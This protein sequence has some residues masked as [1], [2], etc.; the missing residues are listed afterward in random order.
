MRC[1]A[2]LAP[3]LVLALVL[4]DQGAVLARTFTCAT[5]PC[6]DTRRDDDITGTSNRDRICARDGADADAWPAT[7]NARGTFAGLR[8]LAFACLM[9]HR[10]VSVVAHSP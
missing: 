2:L 8:F 10:L 4:F 6:E 3:L 7:T 1:A 5:N 9:L